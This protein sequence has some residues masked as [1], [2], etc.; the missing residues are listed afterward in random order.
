MDEHSRNQNGAV[1]VVGA[2]PTGLTMA[3]DTEALLAA[4]LGDF[5]VKVRRGLNW[6]L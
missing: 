5:G 2:G 6:P 3:I 4:R 1:L